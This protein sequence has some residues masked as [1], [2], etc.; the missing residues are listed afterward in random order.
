MKLEK[1]PIKSLINY[2]MGGKRDRTR[3]FHKMYENRQGKLKI[4]RNVNKATTK[5]KKKKIKMLSYT[6]T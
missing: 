1:P 6:Y 4:K 3:I 2:Y 5:K